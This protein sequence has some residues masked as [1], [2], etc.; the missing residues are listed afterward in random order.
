MDL[1]SAS[2][3]PTHPLSLPP[4]GPWSTLVQPMD[5]WGIL[6]NE[7][8]QGRAVGGVRGGAQLLPSALLAPRAPTGLT[9]LAARWAAVL[10]GES[11]LG[12][13]LDGYA[14][15]PMREPTPPLL[16][17]ASPQSTLP[18]GFR[19]PP[20]AARQRPVPVEQLLRTEPVG[21][22]GEEG[23]RRVIESGPHQ[24]HRS[25]GTAPPR[26]AQLHGTPS[27]W[28]SPGGECNTPTAAAALHSLNACRPARGGGGG[29]SAL[30]GQVPHS[31][32]SRPRAAGVDTAPRAALIPVQ[33]AALRGVLHAQEV[34][35]RIEV[36]TGAMLPP[37][38]FERAAGVLS[39]KWRFTIK[40]VDTGQT[41]GDWLEAHGLGHLCSQRAPGGAHPAPQRR[42]YPT[43]RIS[44]GGFGTAGLGDFVWPDEEEDARGGGVDDDVAGGGVPSMEDHSSDEDY[45]TR[46]KRRRS[47]LGGQQWAATGTP[48]MAVPSIRKATRG[49]SRG[50]ASAG[51]RG[52]GRGWSR[53]RRV[54]GDGGSGL[55]A[56]PH[57]A[58]R[59]GA[60]STDVDSLEESGR[61]WAA[62]AVESP[63][64]GMGR[65][66]GAAKGG[67]V[68]GQVTGEGNT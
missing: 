11:T 33:C 14:T 17:G 49:R 13:G 37:L 20:R 22:G 18:P 16:L 54:E 30:G 64:S 51:R 15:P 10:H 67:G 60:E 53:G 39:K 5:A 12:A 50:G 9:P 48:D 2:H 68:E 41:L 43:S 56:V 46:T 42:S 34:P 3:V 32:K 59:P 21:P 65:A 66:G 1:T 40:L 4:Q 58:L 62:G 63:Q 45:S 7:P 29:G 23:R 25:P 47:S 55:D 35:L 8:L 28:H 38:D 52:R 24:P 61:G 36:P 26:K 19:P 44:A 6:L 31:Q 27:P 57:T